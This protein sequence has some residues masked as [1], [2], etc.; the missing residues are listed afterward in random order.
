VPPK[1]RD[2]I[3]ELSRRASWTGAAG[4]ATATSFT[5]RVRKP[6]TLSGQ[7]CDDALRYQ[8]RAVRLAIEESKR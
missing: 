7:P 5:P 1:V 3:R 8:E 6:L 2:L 4:E